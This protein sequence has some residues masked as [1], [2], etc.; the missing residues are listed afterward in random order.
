[1]PGKRGLHTARE[2]FDSAVDDFAL[3]SWPA[4]STRPGPWTSSSTSACSPRRRIT[5]LRRV[6]ALTEATYFP[7]LEHEAISR[8]FPS[9]DRSANAT[10]R[11]RGCWVVRRRQAQDGRLARTGA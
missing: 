9:D 8:F 7:G 3:N 2:L 10:D 11:T 5:A 6:C 1:M 4:T